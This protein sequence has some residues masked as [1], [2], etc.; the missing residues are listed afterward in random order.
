M[1]VHAF[2]G[3]QVLTMDPAV[4]E[5]E[6]LI[7]D[8]DRIV[9]AGDD[10]LL[11][12][13]PQ[14]TVIDLAGRTLLPGLIDAHHHLSLA[15]LQPRWADLAAVGDLDGLGAALQV[16]ARR[17]PSAEWIRA[18]GWEK[19][20]DWPA[21]VTRHD[22]DALGLDRPII[23]AHYSIHQGL[24]CSRG[25]Q[26][27]GIGRHTPDPVGGEIVRDAAGQPTGMLRETAW[28][29]VHARS[30]AGYADPDRWGE[31][32]VAGLRALH[33]EGVTCVHDAACPPAA[34]AVYQRLAA[35][36]ELPSSVL[37][38]P[39]PAELLSGLDVTRLRG[40]TT[41]EGDEWLRVG[42]VKLF[43]DG[44]W[45]PR[46]GGHLM[47]PARTRG[48]GRR[49]GLVGARGRTPRNVAGCWLRA[50]AGPG[51]GEGGAC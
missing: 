11:T 15:A 35:H 31:Y 47:R 18:A 23:V 4:G 49:A 13:W 10:A 2:R 5:P 9:A 17:E 1:S 6:L 19:Y 42:P 7:V 20:G 38:M 39:H 25:L 3:G 33:A 28:S 43:A 21:P 8:G 48:R 22:L 45:V 51:I 26:Q 27:L 50:G 12:R 34:E 46:T 40:P 44:V 16:Q 30:L 14:A 37:V 24:V 32:I 29:I 36:A 41:G